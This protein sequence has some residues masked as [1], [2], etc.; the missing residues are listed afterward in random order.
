MQRLSTRTAAVRCPFVVNDMKRIKPACRRLLPFGLATPATD[1]DRAQWKANKQ[2]SRQLLLI[3]HRGHRVGFHP[4]EWPPICFVPLEV[5]IGSCFIHFSCI[6]WYAKAS[7]FRASTGATQRKLNC[8][9]GLSFS[10]CC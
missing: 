8:F 3:L 1:I 2:L 4:S 7:G 9:F 6:N 5:R 10:E